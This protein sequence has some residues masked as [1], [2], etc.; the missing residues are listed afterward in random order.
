[1]PAYKPVFTECLDH[2]LIHAGEA[3]SS[4]W[5]CLTGPIYLQRVHV[6]GVAG[7]AKEGSVHSNYCQED[8]VCSCPASSADQSILCRRTISSVL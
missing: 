5:C 1:V 6:L 8:E 2:F 3:A 4:A 7:A